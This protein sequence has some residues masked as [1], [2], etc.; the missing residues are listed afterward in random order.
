MF[1]APAPQPSPQPR[2]NLSIECLAKGDSSDI[3][4]E[5]RTQLDR[6]VE[7]LRS[8][9]KSISKVPLIDIMQRLRVAPEPFEATFDEVK[10]MHVPKPPTMLFKV[11][12]GMTVIH[13]DQILNFVTEKDLKVINPQ[14][15]PS[16]FPG[17]EQPEM[18]LFGEREEW[19]GEPT[20]EERLE[21][22][23]EHARWVRIQK[24][25]SGNPVLIV[26]G[27]TFV[28]YAVHLTE[29]SRDQPGSMMVSIE[30]RDL[31]YLLWFHEDETRNEVIVYQGEQQSA[32][33][34]TR[35]DYL[36]AI[37]AG[38]NLMKIATRR[39]KGE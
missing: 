35:N 1:A 8:F 4:A 19:Q 9:H 33:G 28:E 38:E 34:H 17:A 22:L 11:K 14:E 26:N 39:L 6:I 13:A 5:L 21:D 31:K 27:D 25:S 12:T 23:K 36:T 16:L 7:R 2:V 3:A 37:F 15:F 10:V 24:D 29:G 32:R 30:K 20:L 18:P